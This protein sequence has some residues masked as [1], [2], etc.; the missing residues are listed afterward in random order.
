MRGPYA[1]AH[2]RT[3]W[4]QMQSLRASAHELASPWLVRPSIALVHKSQRFWAAHVAG[5]K[6]V[7]LETGI[8]DQILDRAVEINHHLF[9]SKPELD[10][11]A[12]NARSALG[13]VHVR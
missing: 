13:H 11:P 3:T 8:F 2:K 1:P 7:K 5:L 6:T 4:W 9:V 12:T 10:G